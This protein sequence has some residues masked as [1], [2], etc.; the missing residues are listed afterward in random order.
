MY[1]WR[2]ILKK[3][4]GHGVDR[5]DRTG[6]GTRALFGEQLVF[7]N[8]DTFPAVTLKKL[9][10][11]QVTAEL[12]CFIRGYDN[13]EEF[14]GLGCNIWDAN[15]QSEWWQKKALNDDDL[16]RIYGTQWRRWQGCDEYGASYE[17]DQLK[18]LVDGIR[19]DP[20]GR[21]HIVTAWQPA[22]LGQMC[23]PPCHILFQ[24]FVA[25]G[26]LDLRVDMRSVDL[27][28]GLP[29][30]IA[31]Y[32]ILQR[33]IA[34]ACGFQ[35]GWLIFQLGDAHIYKNHFQQVHLALSREEYDPPT[36][37]MDEDCQ[38]FTFEPGQVSLASYACHSAIPA[39]MNV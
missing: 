6:V 34:R 12:A 26:K 37:K 27:F 14:H 33:L 1:E 3:V 17:L 22:E 10:F 13:L 11:G 16:G 15:C 36:L 5:P 24:C 29:F 28:L 20:Y 35:S 2:R 7:E 31:S 39:I 32:A 21:R 9:A 38:L 4:M 30:D 18:M 23:L 25:D 19:K 8:S